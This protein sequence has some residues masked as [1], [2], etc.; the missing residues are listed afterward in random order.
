MSVMENL[1]VRLEPPASS[2][3]D[4]GPIRGNTT[5]SKGRSVL[6]DSPGRSSV[7]FSND[8]NTLNP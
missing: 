8:W 2:P 3:E 6:P 1:R 5:T 4:A 7:S